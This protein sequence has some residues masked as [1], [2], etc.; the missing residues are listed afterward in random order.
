MLCLLIVEYTLYNFYKQYMYEYSIIRFY[1][2]YRSS[3]CI[4]IGF[5]VHDV[6]LLII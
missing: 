3:S 5:I 6:V 1:L 4:A 2:D